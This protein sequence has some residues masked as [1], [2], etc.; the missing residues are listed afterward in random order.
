MLNKKKLNLYLILNLY[1]LTFNS[2]SREIR[3]EIVNVSETV[4]QKIRVFKQIQEIVTN[5]NKSKTSKRT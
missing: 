1:I 2:N 3:S 5:F 4:I